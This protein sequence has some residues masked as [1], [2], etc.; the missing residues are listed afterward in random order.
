MSVECEMGESHSVRCRSR[1]VGTYRCIH[2]IGVVLNVMFS[3]LQCALV[4]VSCSRP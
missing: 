2:F 1:R 3:V 4:M